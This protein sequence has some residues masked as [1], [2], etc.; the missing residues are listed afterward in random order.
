LQRTGKPVIRK[1]EVQRLEEFEQQEAGRLG[2]EE[3]KLKTNEEMLQV[4]GG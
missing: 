3:F 4:I 2:L 1:P